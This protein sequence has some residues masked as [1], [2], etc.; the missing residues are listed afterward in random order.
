[1]TQELKGHIDK[2]VR[3]AH[4]AV[5]PF[6]MASRAPA[7]EEHAYRE[8]LR[9]E[10]WDSLKNG[11]KEKERYKRKYMEDIISFLD[12]EHASIIMRSHQK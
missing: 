9:Y 3:V 8:M 5:P 1:V 12:K 4:P 11:W 2:H 10:G 6:T 7:W